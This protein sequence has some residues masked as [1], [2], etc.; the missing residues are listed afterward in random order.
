MMAVPIIL[1]AILLVAA[2][3]S[4]ALSTTI[5]PFVVGV[6]RTNGRRVVVVE[7]IPEGFD[8]WIE[9]C[10]SKFLLPLLLALALEDAS[11]GAVVDVCNVAGLE[12]RL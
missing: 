11:V 3:K 4:S 2:S 8:A 6:A 10:R 5:V 7:G 1:V 12:E 9:P